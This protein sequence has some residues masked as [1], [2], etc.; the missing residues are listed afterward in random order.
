MSQYRYWAKLR[1]AR[2]SHAEL[3]ELYYAVSSA[4]VQREGG[5]RWAIEL[6]LPLGAVVLRAVEVEQ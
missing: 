5:G 2:L 6:P 3:V 1:L 4:I